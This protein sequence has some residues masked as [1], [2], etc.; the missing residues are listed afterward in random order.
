MPNPRPE[1][2]MFG[3]RHLLQGH[4]AYPLGKILII[5]SI[6]FQQQV[7]FRTMLGAVKIRLYIIL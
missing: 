2:D 4:S 1:L 6:I 7:A 5:V 3:K